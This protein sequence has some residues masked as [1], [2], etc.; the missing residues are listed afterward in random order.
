MT[1]AIGGVATTAKAAADDAPAAADGRG[2]GSEVVD[3]F[4]KS[5]VRAKTDGQRAYLDTIFANDLTICTGPA[6]TGKT[7]L[8]VAAAAALLKQGRAKRLILT[9]PAV[10]AGE[11]LGF[12]PGDLQAKVNPYLRP[13]FDALGDMMDAEQVRRFMVNDVIEVV[14]LAFM[15][16]R[17]QPLTSQVLTPFGFRDIGSVAVGDLVTGSDG[18]PTRVLGVYPQGTK[19]V[20]RVTF[21]DG[22]STRCCG[23]HL[24]TVLT[25][26]DKRRGRPPRVL[27]TSEIA[28]NTHSAHQH[29]YEIPT[30]SAPAAFPARPVP[31]DP[32]AMGLLLGDGCL[33]GSTT[34]SFATVDAELVGALA[35]ALP[36]VEVRHKT[37]P[38]YV[39]TGGDRCNRW[40]P[41]PVTHTLRAVGPSGT[42]S[43]TKFVPADYLQN[44]AD[45]RLS[46]LQGL[47]D[48][49]G[50]PVLQAGRTSRVQYTTTSPRLR[51]DV[52]FLVQS[53]GGVATVRHRPAA[54][55]VP[56]L[57]NGRPVPYRN[58]AHV[59][60]IR[61]PRDI[62]PFRLTRKAERYESGGIGRP[63]RFIHAVE[64]DG[65]EP[66]VCIR[67]AAADALYCTD[68]FILTHNTLSDSV[69]IL[70]RRRT[71]PCRRC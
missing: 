16:G 58:D 7:Y 32:Y 36:A 24:W 18:R 57:A 56:G 71:R 46:V 25:P 4:A 1:R 33:T 60:D 40:T 35:T 37:G 12:L 9:R 52:R 42:R 17:A 5:G 23:E 38:D 43:S 70:T 55:R 49:D 67:V 66:C 39:L 22:T 61:L 15:R 31:M 21:T 13:L 45:V 34:P 11:R 26:A 2:G 6:G 63:M 50:G 27:Q 10:E 3:T 14:P 8:A 59:L 62:K 44:S 54:G 48:T 65:T 47:L 53:L 51:D 20:F 28:R 29:R 68:S 30:L 41:N 19:D 64:P 69:I